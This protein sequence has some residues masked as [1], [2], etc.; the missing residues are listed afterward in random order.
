MPQL[1]PCWILQPTVSGQ[2]SNLHHHS[3][4]SCC[5][6]IPN[7]LCHCGNSH[8]LTIL[9]RL[10]VLLVPS[11]WGQ[12]CCYTPHEAQGGPRNKELSSNNA[13]STKTEKP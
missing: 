2:G 8:L 4:P 10:G 11:G 5:S 3:D 1:W 12:E 9:T 6:Q 13:N 7:P